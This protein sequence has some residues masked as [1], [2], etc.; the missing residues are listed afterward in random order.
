MKA[1]G[2]NRSLYQPLA[3]I[4]VTPLIDVMLVLLIVF[5][6]TAPML[7]AGM[8]VDLPQAKSA[9]PVDPKE[10]VI[11]TVQKDG[12]LFLGRDEVAP[13]QVAAAVRAKLG[14][15]RDRAI[16]LRGDREAAY[17]EM[18]AVMDQLSASGFVK[19]ALIANARMQQGVTAP[20]PAASPN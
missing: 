18:V 2:P 20:A 1:P 17:G 8:R 13:G 19:V 7:A 9:Q 4:N 5:M 14:A 16:H 10:P 11:I 12:K 6:I 3:E 15:D